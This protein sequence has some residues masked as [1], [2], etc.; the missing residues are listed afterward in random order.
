MYRWE[1]TRNQTKNHSIVKPKQ[2]DLN[3]NYRSHNG[4]LQLAA[5][6]VD[7]IKRFFPDSI[8]HD[9]SRERAEIGGPKPIVDG[10]FNK[11]SFST[12]KFGHSQIIIV[13][14]DEAKSRLKKLIGEGALVM[15]VYDAKGM[16]FDVVI[17][18]NFFTDSLAL[19]K[20]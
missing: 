14:D 20:V 15:T 13:R 1:L 5:S 7:L 12:V 6:V 16:E 18:Y 8:D 11:N 4:I 2:F 19:R 17:L 10:K 3:V 9:L